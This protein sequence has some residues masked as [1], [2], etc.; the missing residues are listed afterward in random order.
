MTPTDPF[1]GTRGQL[2]AE[3]DVP[4]GPAVPPAPRASRGRSLTDRGAVVMAFAAAA[5]AWWAGPIP[6]VVAG[7]VVV[8]AFAL[9]RPAV[10]VLGA[11]A[12]AAALGARSHAGLDPVA[13]GPYDGPVTLLGDPEPV[14]YGVRVDVRAGER[15]LEMIA[16]DGAAGSVSASLAGERLQVRGR[17]RPPPPDAPW[18]VPRHVVGRLQVSHAERLHG[19][20]LP[21]RA[22]N[23]VRRLLGRGAEVLP[24]PARS[25]YGGFVLGDDRDQPPEVVDDFRAAGL[26]HVLVVSGQ[27]LAFLMVLATPLTDRL[28]LAGRWAATMAI[29]GAFA[30]ITRFE[31]SVLRA[32]AM[33]VLAVTGA[34]A[35]RPSGTLRRLAL[36]VTVLVLVDPLL[37]HAVAFQLSVAASAGIAVGAA[38]ISG[39]APGPRWWRDALGVTLSAQIGVAPVLIPRF[40]GMPVVSVLANVL[41]VPVS[42]LVTTWGLPAGIVAGVAG[43]EVGAVVHVPTRVLIEWVAGVARVAAGL[44]TGELDG[45]G[46]V[47]V[48]G[49]TTAWLALRSRPP[50]WR[51]LGAVP[52]TIAVAALLAPAAALRYP[53][54]VQVTGGA[55]VHRAGGAT[56]VVLSDDAGAADLLEDLRMVG[57]RRLDVIVAPQVPA[58]DVLGALSHRWPVGRVIGV[59]DS[60]GE[61]LRVGDLVVDTTAASADGDLAGVVRPA[62]P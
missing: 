3:P 40:G 31:P 39:R 51:A 60:G 44:P 5:G 1:G 55:T 7:A 33:A 15:R 47:A 26:T 9:R 24:E 2:P 56:V 20:S 19:G 32:S 13:P 43:P 61:R 17:L 11:F 48:M 23:Q 42:G 30:V 53:P 18:L 34:L 36:G 38:A 28:P 6:L 37:V 27:N 54:A 58:A 25:L 49:A 21:W 10:L 59:E 62:P 50:P 57:V 52:A 22:A 14:A 29:I 16:A 4:A 41:A 46:F 12:L 45:W 8:A 35:G